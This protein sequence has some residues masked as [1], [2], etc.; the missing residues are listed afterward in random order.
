VDG[1]FAFNGAH[2]TYQ[3]LGQ[4]QV[5]NVTFQFKVNDGISNFNTATV[6]V[7][8]T[9]VNDVSMKQVCDFTVNEDVLINIH[10]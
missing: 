9:G 6:T 8:L 5:Q 7:K 1:M 2:P 3:S 10:S 4:G